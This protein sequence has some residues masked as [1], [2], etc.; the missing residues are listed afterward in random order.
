[1]NYPS[2]SVSP[3]KNLNERLWVQSSAYLLFVRGYAIGGLE[4]LCP[5]EETGWKCK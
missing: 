1:M 4:K 2:K 3:L 5:M